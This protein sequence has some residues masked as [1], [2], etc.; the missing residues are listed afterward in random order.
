MN[1]ILSTRDFTNLFSHIGAKN[2][3]VGGVDGVFVTKIVSREKH[4][5]LRMVV[6]GDGDI[7]VGFNKLF[8]CQ[9]FRF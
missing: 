8:Q 6:E 4:I 5:S 2:I 9:S 7:F 1:T 3:H